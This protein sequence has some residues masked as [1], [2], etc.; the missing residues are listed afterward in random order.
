MDT[1]LAA[2]QS[3]TYRAPAGFEASRMLIGAIVTFPDSARIVCCMVS[4]APRRLPDG[5]VDTVTIPF[6]PMTEPAFRASAVAPDGAA[7][8]DEG[9]VMALEAWQ[10]DVR[11]LSA[12]SVPFE[13]FLDRMIGLQ[14]AAIVG[15]T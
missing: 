14:M 12:F 7:A 4:G 10:E 8:V 15:T 1:E 13:G 5:T 3:W 11:G 9:F 2:G 6:L